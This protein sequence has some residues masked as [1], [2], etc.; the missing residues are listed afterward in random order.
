MAP[1]SEVHRT[2]LVLAA[3][4]SANQNLGLEHM[5]PVRCPIGNWFLASFS[6]EGAMTI[7]SFVAIKAP[8]G[9]LFQHPSTPRAIHNSDTLSRCYLAILV[10]SE[11]CFDLF[12]VTL[13]F[14]LL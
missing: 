11:R 4:E 12:L 8:H 9:N 13:V 3:K 7:G 10:R 1:I 14:A 6:K 2:G 5:N